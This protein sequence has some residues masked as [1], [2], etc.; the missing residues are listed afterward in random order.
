[1]FKWLLNFV[2]GVGPFLSAAS[3][4]F[5]YIFTPS[6]MVVWVPVVLVA[7]T[8]GFVYVDFQNLKKAETALVVQ[9]AADKT[10]ISTLTNDVEVERQSIVTLQ[11]NLTNYQ[12]AVQN[13]AAQQVTFRTQI[14]ALRSKLSAAQFIKKAQTDAPGASA[15]L[16]SA[17]GALVLQLRTATGAS[18]ADASQGNPSKGPAAASV[19]AGPAKPAVVSPQKRDDGP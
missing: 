7:G 12:A 1:M 13:Y 3:G 17:Y 2:P 6:R 5:G 8:I 10:T 19:P 16:N 14:A 11:T 9:V 15:D 18:G 4:V